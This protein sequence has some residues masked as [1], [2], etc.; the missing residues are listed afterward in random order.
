MPLE[1]ILN[2]TLIAED[3][4]TGYVTLRKK[5]LTR[6]EAIESIYEEYE[7]ELEDSDDRVGVLMGL[8]KA[9]SAKKELIPEIA[10]EALL[11]IQKASEDPNL[12]K[13]AQNS[14][15][16]VEALIQDATRYGEEATYSKKRVFNPTWQ[17]GDLF[18]HTIKNPETE[19]WGTLGMTILVHIVGHYISQDGDYNHLAVVAICK[20]GEE[21]K[22]ADDL[23]YLYY[24]ANA[25]HKKTAEYIWQLSPTSKRSEA[26][27][28][29]TKIGNYPIAYA[30][31]DIEYSDPQ[32][33]MPLFECIKKAEYP[34]YEIQ[35]SQWYVHTK[36]RSYF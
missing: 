33:V 22:T 8:V 19:R 29:F 35:V 24:I 7:S 25:F 20:P 15:K 6:K 21:P 4:K 23:P 34:T 9:L 14:F 18:A 30:P 11:E 28:Q 12:K 10:E 13:S 32:T 16:R 3:V 36:K 17:K 31:D 2:V 27:F 5:G 26:A 1:E